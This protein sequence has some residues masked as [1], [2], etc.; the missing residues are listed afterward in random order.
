MSSLLRCLA[1]TAC[2]PLAAW[3]DEIRLSSV[4]TPDQMEGYYIDALT[5][6]NDASDRQ[7]PGIARITQ[8]A[9]AL[10][11]GDVKGAGLPGRIRK[12]FLLFRLPALDGKKLSGATL[13]LFLGNVLHEKEDQPMPPPWLFHAGQWVDENW[14][15]APPMRGLRPSHFSDTDA[16]ADKIPFWDQDAKPGVIELDVTTMIRRDYERSADPVTAFRME[17]SD[18]QTLDITDENSNSYVFYGPGMLKNPDRV[19]MLVLSFE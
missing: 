9:Q 19:P 3:A 6:S 15:S 13:R 12:G 14:L 2:I 11:V 16:F 17:V 10:Q 7:Q 4:E 18:P 5:N 1:V 8:E